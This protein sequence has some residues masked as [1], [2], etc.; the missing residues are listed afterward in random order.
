MPSPTISNLFRRQEL[1]PVDSAVIRADI[2]QDPVVNEFAARPIAGMSGEDTDNT[3]DAENTPRN[4]DIALSPD[5]SSDAPEGTN[6]SSRDQVA[7][8]SNVVQGSITNQAT[9]EDDP[10]FDPTNMPFE[11]M[12]AGSVTNE[13]DGERTTASEAAIGS[14]RTPTEEIL[15][16]EQPGTALDDA[17]SGSPSVTDRP[18]TMAHLIDGA[19]VPAGEAAHTFSNTA[20]DRTNTPTAAHQYR[21]EGNHVLHVWTNSRSTPPPLTRRPTPRDISSGATMIN[22][23]T[24]AMRSTV[25]STAAANAAADHTANPVFNAW[26]APTGAVYL[27]IDP[28]TIARQSPQRELQNQHGTAVTSHMSENTITPGN[29]LHWMVAGG[30]LLCSATLVAIPGRWVYTRWRQRKSNYVRK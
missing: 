14:V 12:Q 29:P 30:L 15:T 8:A 17:G 28:G 21:R 22:S 13:P 3:E 5:L 1:I 27:N 26:Q 10:V 25:I 19:A 9:T 11:E 2:A 6:E 4:P 23:S 24:T 7:S 18:E 16:T 20:L